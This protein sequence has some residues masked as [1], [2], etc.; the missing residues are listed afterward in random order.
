MMFGIRIHVLALPW[1]VIY[2]PA[3][4]PQNFLSMTI[5]LNMV[6]VVALHIDELRI[7][8]RM[9]MEMQNATLA[10]VPHDHITDFILL[11]WIVR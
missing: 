7:Q 9:Q 8:G 4:E 11:P 1:Y 10:F 3:L 5:I 2:Y 6:F